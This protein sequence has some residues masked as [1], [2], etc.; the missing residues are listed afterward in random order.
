MKKVLVTPLDW[1]LGHATR[2]VPIINELLKRNCTVVIGGC[3]E[4]LE[5]LKK[6]FP[7]LTFLSLPAYKPVYPS[8]G[9]MVLK[10]LTQLPRFLSTIKQE[11]AEIEQIIKD[12]KIDL[13][14]SDNRFGCWSAA[15][16][17]VFVTH[18][19]NILLPKRFK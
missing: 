3:G 8:S 1:G 14:I 17:S 6:E 9:S 2:C 15:V 5:L 13:I 16:P 12:S 4:S 11:H 18:Q 19:T 7:A 10:M